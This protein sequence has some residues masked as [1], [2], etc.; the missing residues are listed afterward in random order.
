MK[1]LKS[2][3]QQL[4]ISQDSTIF[5]TDMKKELMNALRLTFSS[6]NHLLCI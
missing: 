4:K 6:I 1:Q 5:V 2:L 3:Y